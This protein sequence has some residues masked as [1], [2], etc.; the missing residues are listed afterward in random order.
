MTD[1]NAGATDA[2]LLCL[3]AAGDRNAFAV[4]Y[5]RYQGIAFRFALQMSGSQATAED[6]T[7]EAFLALMRDARRY[8]PTK[9]RFTTYLYGMVR[10]LT[11]RRMGRDRT[12]VRLDPEKRD[13]DAAGEAARSALDELVDRQTIHVVRQAVLSLPSRYREV[14]VLCDLHDQSYADAAVVIGCA[15]GTVRSRLHRGRAMLRDKLQRRGQ[16]SSVE[17]ARSSRCYA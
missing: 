14:V 1:A 3:T 8:D 5:R 9:A 15:V 7:Q 2:E 11:R 13:Q 10:R 16:P 6:V 17:C 12:F 4:F